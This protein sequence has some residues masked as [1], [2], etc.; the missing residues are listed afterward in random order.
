MKN[1]S[2]FSMIAVLATLAVIS[3]VIPIVATIN[4]TNHII[5]APIRAGEDDGFV[6]SLLSQGNLIT[7]SSSIS[8]G[9]EAEDVFSLKFSAYLRFSNITIPTDA[10]ISKAYITVVPT[11]TN[12]TGPLME[13]TAVN[14]SNPTAPKNYS[15]YSTRNKTEA[16]VDWNASYW[17]E[18]VSVNS[19]DISGIIQELVNSYDYNYS[20]ST[21][22]PILIFLDDLDEEIRTKY[23]AFAAYEHQDYEPAKLHI[24]YVTEKEEEYKVHNINTGEGFSTIQAA[25]DDPDTLDGHTITVDPGTYTENVNVTKSLTIKSS[26][27]NPGDTIVQAANPNDHVFA[28]T[29]DYVNISGFTITGGEEGISISNYGSSRIINN[30]ILNN[31]QAGIYVSYTN[32]NLFQKNII[33]Y[34]HA[35]I[36]LKMSNNNRIINNTLSDTLTYGAICLNHLNTNN[37]I[38]DNEIFRNERGIW[39]VKDFLGHPR[40][41][42]LRNN[43]IRNNIYGLYFDDAV[44]TT[45][46]LNNFINNACHVVGGGNIFNSSSK[47]TYTYNGNRYTNYLGNYWDDYKEKYPD[48]EEIDSTGIWDDA[49]SIDSDKDNYPLTEPWEEYEE[50]EKEQPLAKPTGW[51]H[52]GY[53]L[54][55]T[56]FYP[57]PS[58]TS[59]SNFDI[60][61]TSTNKGKILTGDINGDGEL[62]LVSA[63]EERVCA[64]DKNGVLSWSKNITTDSGIAGA[65]VNSLDLDDMDGDNIPEI[66]VGIS[67]AVPYPHVNKPLRILF[68]NGAGNLL[69]TISTPDSHVI[70]VKCADLNNDGRKEVIA[71][72]QAWYTLKP[73]GVY[74]YDYNTGNELWHYNIGPQL[75]IDS[76][77]DINNDGNK[78][79]VVGT[80]A[81]HNG[82][83]DHGTDDSLSYVFAFDKDGNNLWTKQIGWDS[84]Y[85]S[86]ADLNND[87]NP[88]IISFRNQNEPYYPG[89]NDVY[90]LNPANGNTVDTYNGPANKGWKGWAIAD[91]NGDGKKEIVVGNRDGTLRVLDCNLNLIDSRSLSGTVQAINDVNGNG[92]QEIIVCTDDK[93]IVILDN[94]LN[95]LWSYKYKLDAKG[96]AIVSDLI[97]NGT[98]EIIVSADKLYVFSGIGG[99]KGIS[100]TQLTRN[101]ADDRYPAWSPDGSKI[102]FQSDRDGNSE[103]YVMNADGTN[104]VKLTSNTAED[105]TPAWSPDGCKIAFAS[106]RDSECGI[107]VMDT[108]GTNVIPLTSHTALDCNPKWSPDGSKIT[109]QSD[110]DGNSEIYVMNADGTNVTKLTSNTAED[111]TPAW[112]PDGCKIAFASDRDFI[113]FKI[114]VMD[115]D[116]TNVI[117]L[118]SHTAPAT[119]GTP[120]WSPDGR[121]IAFTSYRDNSEN[122]YV[123]DAD[124]TNVIQLTMNT[125]A[126]SNP[127]WSPDGSKIAFCSDR[128]GDYEV[129]VTDVE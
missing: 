14:H 44:N 30:K 113:D 39:F 27:G 73:R 57:Y 37:T 28:V 62:E 98:N 80:F 18:G 29:A 19:P 121:K 116:G 35:G 128:D 21:G 72:I 115:T 15:D 17:Y 32:G 52:S 70:D 1:K 96:S 107:Y 48:A 42:V 47:I 97:P 83:S 67:P 20:T 23:Q 76:I 38:E 6:T 84:V 31:A 100:V 54:D 13:I 33:R 105:W 55:N 118:T 22:A 102:A 4:P 111:R 120:A 92:K 85:S 60:S 66:V 106:D 109:F 78:E 99:E 79:I 124:G 77:A 41:N 103:I 94:E 40:D 110:R 8:I 81:P 68:Y 74:V 87:G 75:W 43:S 89:A 122:I 59:V 5:E 112:P 50:I 12:R 71:T 108:D 24:E 51:L 10:K 49:Y 64:M 101:T 65:K 63:F 126:D 53:D 46:Y 91:I 36:L 114:Y 56:R 88:E 3:S 129:Y 34:S 95:E 9:Q 58:K 69:K 45:V 93:R 82:N 117:P 127:D 125:A 61:W 123:M 25:I 86:V 119:D 11:F 90:I 7:D 26:S 104:V 16:S 2:L